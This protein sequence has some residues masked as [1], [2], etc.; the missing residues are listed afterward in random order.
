MGGSFSHVVLSVGYYDKSS[1]S[2]VICWEEHE[3]CVDHFFLLP[4][5]STWNWCSLTHLCSF[6]IDLQ[7]QIASIYS[8]FDAFSTLDIISLFSL[9]HLKPDVST[10][11]SAFP[12]IHHEW[13]IYKGKVFS[14]GLHPI[15]YHSL[16]VLLYVMSFISFSE[17]LYYCARLVFLCITLLC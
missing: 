8:I 16:P 1:A 5:G 7:L 3:V 14:A 13:V 12:L 9:W 17:S 11:R 6:F 4:L 2:G 10:F 15:P